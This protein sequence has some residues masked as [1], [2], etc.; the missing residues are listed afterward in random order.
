MNLE[1]IKYPNPILT[2]PCQ[3]VNTTD[4]AQSST[5]EIID[6]ILGFFQNHNGGKLQRGSWS[7]LS[8]NQ[9]GIELRLFVAYLD[10]KHVYTVINPRLRRSPISNVRLESCASVPGLQ[11]NI[12]RS[13]QVVLEALD[14]HGNP[15][16]KTLGGFYAASVLH[17]ID[18]LNGK[19]I[20]D[21]H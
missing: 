4:L 15:F 9:V 14:R 8:A 16:K 7:G 5:Q 21:R 18:H 17:E 11:L 13:N 19:L 3:E 1:I 2:K 6:N 20:T 10:D 12:R